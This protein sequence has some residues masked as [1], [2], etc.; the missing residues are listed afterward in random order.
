MRFREMG[1]G[2]IIILVFVIA[3]II[4]PR[5]L[6]YNN[7]RSIMLYVPLM[8]VVAMGQLMVIVSRNIDLS[9][10][11]TLAFSGMSVGL[12]LI[13]YPDFPIW[14]AF[15]LGIL[16]GAVL[17]AING[18][19]I[20]GLDLP[21]I[22][23]TLGT[24]NVYRGLSFIIS[25]GKQIDPNYIPVDLIKLSQTSPI[26]VP[27][28][29]IFAI[30][31]V[32]IAYIF[33]NY[34]HIGR[35]IYAIGSNPDAAKLRGI[36]VKYILLLIFTITGAVAGFAGILYASR[37]G[38]VNPGITGVGFELKVIAATVIGG[39]SITGGIGT[40]L[41]AVLGCTLLGVVNTAL[42]VLGISAFW[43]KASYGIIILVALIVDKLIRNKLEHQ[44]KRGER[45]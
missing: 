32:I 5:F 4:E 28:I 34:S 30:V 13:K 23:V 16:I 39:A 3:S 38:Y 25:G 19:L 37:F 20:T 35:E 27:W 11:S 24:L 10:G 44:G 45:A 7:L 43:Q 1:I 18:L 22:I 12:L 17:G 21:A 33:L 41:G 26:K 15:L 2:F 40:V 31:I 42:S 29:V 36:K 14:L 6:K 9:I 8:V